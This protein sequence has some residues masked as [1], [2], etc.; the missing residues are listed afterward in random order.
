[1][2]NW[3][4]YETK[5]RLY[6]EDQRETSI[7][8]TK[9]MILRK[10]LKNPMCKKVM[11]DDKPRKLLV[12]ATALTTKKKIYALPDENISLGSIVLWNESHWII[13]E[14]D[15][16]YDISAQGAIEMCNR[17]LTWQNTETKEIHSRWATVQKPYYSNIDENEVISTSS[18]EFKV[19]MPYDEES[20]L[21]D[22][23]KRFMLEIIA[24]EPKTYRCTSVDSITERYDHEEGLRGFLVINLTQD[25]YNKDVDNVKLGI[26]DY[27][28]PES[29]DS[30]NDPDDSSAR[31]LYSG[32]PVIKI[33][34]NAK[35]FT[36]WQ[37]DS[38]TSTFSWKVYVAD[39]LRN[40]ITVVEDTMSISL[41]AVNNN[42]LLDSEIKLSLMNN[43]NEVD[44]VIVK[45]VSL[46]G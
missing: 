32:E 7:S 17:Q 36:I 12:L 38:D 29:H 18:R 40:L 6:G 21:I 15:K 23:D 11:I 8:R 3:E 30:E 9:R 37:D 20:A 5:M 14:V 43:G 46:F 26:C 19:Q 45:V 39:H 22:V 25:Q 28:E 41:K 13:T 33:G 10:M 4:L 2:T 44:Y 35:T 34:G 31:I 1:M 24:G 42:L 16:D 27:I